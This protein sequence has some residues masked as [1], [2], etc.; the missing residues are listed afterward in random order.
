MKQATISIGDNISIQL[1][2]WLRQQDAPPPFDEVIQSAL[3]E[4]LANRSMAVPRH[5]LRVT[6]SAMGSG[7]DDISIAHDC[8]LAAE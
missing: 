8:Y 1:D 5:R 2:S 7:L 6:P 3:E 4:F